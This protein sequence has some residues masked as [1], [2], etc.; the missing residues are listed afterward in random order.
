MGSFLE[1]LT[2]KSFKMQ[3]LEVIGNI[4]KDGFLKIE[5]PLAVKNRKVK[6][7]ILFPDDD[8][9]DDSLWLKALANNP[10]LDF[11]NEP[12]ED[13]YTPQHGKPFVADEV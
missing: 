1:N 4:D 5:K 12:E 3:A 11:L 13:I 6:V 9:L 2:T 8:V 7:I 10:S